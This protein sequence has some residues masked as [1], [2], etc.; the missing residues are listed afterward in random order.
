MT[1][2]EFTVITMAGM[3]PRISFRHCLDFVR[4]TN[5]QV[6]QVVSLSDLNK[7]Q[8]CFGAPIF[9]TDTGLG[10]LPSTWHYTNDKFS[11]HKKLPVTIFAFQLLSLP[12]NCQKSGSPLDCTCIRGKSRCILA[13][14]DHRCPDR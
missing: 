5:N 7:R 9:C 8:E 6:G 4:P 14:Q 12:L 11:S 3:R 1:N 2:G 10:L 13:F